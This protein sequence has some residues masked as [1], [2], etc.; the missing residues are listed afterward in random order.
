MSLGYILI[1]APIF[2]DKEEWYGA[3][4]EPLDIAM[5]TNWS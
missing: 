3:T 4:Q 5:K 1:T 2:R